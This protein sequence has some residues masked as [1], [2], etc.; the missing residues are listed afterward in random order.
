MTFRMTMTMPMTLR[1]WLCLQDIHPLSGSFFPP[2]MHS[3]CMNNNGRLAGGRRATKVLYLNFL[4]RIF[5]YAK[6]LSKNINNDHSN[7]QTG[8]LA[9]WPD[10]WPTSKGVLATE[11]LEQA[12]TIKQRILATKRGLV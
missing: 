3:T 7:Y 2:A 6:T 11:S 12:I 4:N 9:G 10:F 1:R 5:E 8:W